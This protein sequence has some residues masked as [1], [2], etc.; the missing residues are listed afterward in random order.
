MKYHILLRH[1]HIKRVVGFLIIVYEELAVCTQLKAFNTT[2]ISLNCKCIEVEAEYKLNQCFLY[3]CT[4]LSARQADKNLR[5]AK[6]IF[7]FNAKKNAKYPF[8][9]NRQCLEPLC[10]AVPKRVV[11]CETLG[12]VL[13]FSN[14]AARNVFVM[15]VTPKDVSIFCQLMTKLTCH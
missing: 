10:S 2:D 4:G 11:V 3:N 7:F 6:E 13:P 14:R 15:C 5:Q 1:F 9:G 8:I 12:C